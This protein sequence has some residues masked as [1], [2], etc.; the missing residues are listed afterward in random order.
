MNWDYSGKLQHAQVDT[1]TIAPDLS[2]RLS[3]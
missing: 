2:Y 3:Q 1:A